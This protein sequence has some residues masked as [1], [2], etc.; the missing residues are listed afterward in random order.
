M[1]LAERCGTAMRPG[2]RSDPAGG[3]PEERTSV[4]WLYIQASPWE[5]PHAGG[6]DERSCRRALPQIEC[7]Q[8]VRVSQTGC[9]GSSL[10][11]MMSA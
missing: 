6:P 4:R 5:V 7:G 9:W 10:C 1:V 8:C 2:G 11:R 3:S